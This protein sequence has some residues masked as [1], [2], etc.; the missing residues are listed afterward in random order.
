MTELI[1]K[2]TKEVL[3]GLK[4]LRETKY[5]NEIHRL[6]WLK[7]KNGNPT[8]INIM[9][10]GSLF[11]NKEVEI[12]NYIKSKYK[13][14]KIIGISRSFKDIH[15]VEATEEFKKNFEAIVKSVNPYYITKNKYWW[16][17]IKEPSIETFD[18]QEAI[19]EIY[20]IGLCC[21]FAPKVLL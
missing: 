11:D 4:T 19:R 14:L 21:G 20:R 18:I 17:G 3:E 9:F 1:I 5:K 6:K 10:Y 13:I 12:F 2:N 7:D 16:V 15:N 8:D